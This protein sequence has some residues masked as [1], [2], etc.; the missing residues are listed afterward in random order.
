MANGYRIITDIDSEELS[1]K[2]VEA[3]RNGW[4]T[5]GALIVTVI[6]PDQ[7]TFQFTQV[8][9]PKPQ[10]NGGQ[11]KENEVGTVDWHWDCCGNCEHRIDYDAGCVKGISESSPEVKED[12][13]GNYICTG[14]LQI[15][16]L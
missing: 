6:N 5:E 7:Y 4:M 10:Y 12:C 9:I 14:F 1:K 2:V 15:K 8:M 16:N 3:M 11:M 13:D